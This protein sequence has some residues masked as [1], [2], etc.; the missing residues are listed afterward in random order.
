MWRS[1]EQFSSASSKGTN[2]SDH[3]KVTNQFDGYSVQYIRPERVI[4][5]IGGTPSSRLPDDLVFCMALPVEFISE[6]ASMSVVR[7]DKMKGGTNGHQGI[8]P[9]LR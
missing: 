8:G 7:A 1:W 3:F 2:D 5:E 6:S 9:R 4:Y